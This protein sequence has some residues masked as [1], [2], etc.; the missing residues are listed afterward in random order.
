MTYVK[1]H[2]SVCIGRHVCAGT[3]TQASTLDFQAY[4]IRSTRTWNG[5]EVVSRL[6]HCPGTTTI[7]PFRRAPWVIT[8]LPYLHSLTT[9]VT[10]HQILPGWIDAC[11]YFLSNNL[12]LFRIS[13]ISFRNVKRRV[14]CAFNSRCGHSCWEMDFSR[15][16]WLILK[17]L[18]AL[19]NKN[20][21]LCE[22][23]T[24]TFTYSN[25]SLDH[26]GQVI[27]AVTNKF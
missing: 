12:R 25:G 5:K 23:W 27:H 21:T 1:I 7:K 6:P 18:Q 9:P 4:H 24:W 19:T 20:S 22:N 3:R 10:S 2:K 17:S 14:K 8:Y 13:C 26:C 11:K 15:N 16:Y